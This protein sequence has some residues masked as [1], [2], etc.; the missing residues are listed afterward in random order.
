M[1]LASSFSKHA[2]STRNCVQD[3]LSLSPNFLDLRHIVALDLQAKGSTDTSTQ[4]VDA[5]ADGHRPRVRETGNL[6]LLVHLGHQLPF[7]DVVGSDVLKNREKPI[8][9]P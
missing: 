1:P 8:G 4:H 2:S 3:A 9:R 6:Q 5:T 7:G